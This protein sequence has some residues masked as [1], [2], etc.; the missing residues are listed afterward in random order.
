ME[1]VDDGDNVR[2]GVDVG[3][4]MSE[5]EETVGTQVGGGWRRQGR[6]MGGGGEG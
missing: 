2:R 1:G 6:G 5:V 4:D 3:D